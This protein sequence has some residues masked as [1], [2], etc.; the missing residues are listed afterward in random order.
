MSTLSLLPC[1]QCAVCM[2]CAHPREP[3]AS[4]SLAVSV[5]WGGQCFFVLGTLASCLALHVWILLGR[6]R[7]GCSFLCL[8]GV[9][10]SILRVGQGSQ[11]RVM[12][13]RVVG[14]LMAIGFTTHAHWRGHPISP[15]LALRTGTLMVARFESDLGPWRG[16]SAASTCT[17][18]RLVH[19]VETSV[20]IIVL[21][22]LGLRDCM[23]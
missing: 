12:C 4:A 13:H 14:N 23:L 6:L 17:A 22:C 5:R 20:Y 1:T 15:V 3:C 9:T 11:S 8:G 7:P 2:T 16:G 21:A 18:R 19:P 10:V